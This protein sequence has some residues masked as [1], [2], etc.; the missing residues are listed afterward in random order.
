MVKLCKYWKGRPTYNNKHEF[1][2]GPTLS[3]CVTEIIVGVESCPIKH[4]H[5]SST[6]ILHDTGSLFGSEHPADGG[7]P[8]HLT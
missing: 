7:L 8:L 6:Y 2:P 3:L 4:T 1:R 5:T